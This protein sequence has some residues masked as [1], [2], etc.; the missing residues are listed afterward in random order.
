MRAFSGVAD[1][2]F[3]GGLIVAAL[4][5]ALSFTVTEGSGVDAAA[6]CDAQ[7]CGAAFRGRF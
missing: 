2:L 3:V 6:A 7:G 1:G 4:G 5:V